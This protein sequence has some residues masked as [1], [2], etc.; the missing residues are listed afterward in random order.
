VVLLICC[1]NL[2]FCEN[3]ASSGSFCLVLVPGVLIYV[4]LLLFLLKGLCYIL[5]F[6]Y[7]L[8]ILSSY[9]CLCTILTRH[10]FLQQV[11][12]SSTSLL[13]SNQSTLHDL[14]YPL[15]PYLARKY[16]IDQTANPRPSVTM[17]EVS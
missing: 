14:E 13:G 5:F 4:K 15:P 6:V 1:L 12:P 2:L 10:L 3:A 11:D 8:N 17:Q 9:L 7:C 16:N